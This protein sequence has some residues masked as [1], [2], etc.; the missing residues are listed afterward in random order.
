MDDPRNYSAYYEKYKF[1]KEKF[2]TKSPYSNEEA[3]LISLIN[4]DNIKELELIIKDV[5]F[6]EY[7]YRL[8]RKILY[9]EKPKII[10]YIL[11]FND[12]LFSEIYNKAKYINNEMKYYL[13]NYYLL[14]TPQVQYVI[15]D[16]MNLFLLYISKDVSQIVRTYIDF[17]DYDVNDIINKTYLNGNIIQSTICNLI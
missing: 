8:I 1:L 12:E 16:F 5:N 4:N 2:I 17:S 11:L 3:H 6:R 15:L 9:K 10:K 13:H 14:K 7:N